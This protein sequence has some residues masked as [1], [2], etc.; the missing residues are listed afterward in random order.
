MSFSLNPY[1]PQLLL[2][3]WL[4]CHIFFNLLDRVS[5]I[6]LNIF[7][8]VTYQSLSTKNQHV[9]SWG[10]SWLL[11]A[12]FLCFIIFVENWT[13]SVMWQLWIKRFLLPRSNS[14][15]A[16]AGP[17]PGSLGWVCGDAETGGAFPG[18]GPSCPSGCRLQLQ[19]SQNCPLRHQAA[20]FTL[21]TKTQTFYLNKLLLILL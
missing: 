8:I 19:T 16:C 13:F 9:N 7:I 15:N 20:N 18:S 11:T 21:L 1:D 3:N 5:L 17:F 14:S 4:Y 12:I 2:M 6:S 10:H